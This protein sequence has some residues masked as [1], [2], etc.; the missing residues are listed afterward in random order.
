M[1][2][3]F[4][5]LQVGQLYERPYLAQLWDCKSHAAISRGIVTPAN[6]KIIVLFVTKEKQRDYTQ[7]KDDFTGTVL[8]MEGE[9]SGR[10]DARLLAS[11]SSSDEIHLFYRPRHHQPFRYC[12]PVRLL[13]H[14]TRVDGSTHFEFETER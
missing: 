13:R 9:T 5:D 7:Y 4:E 10:T 1:F 6:Q 3:A 14:E 8:Q 11:S 12:G 2:I